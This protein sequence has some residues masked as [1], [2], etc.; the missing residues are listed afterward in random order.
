MHFEAAQ[1]EERAAS[2]CRHDLAG[3]RFTNDRVN[4]PD[5]GIS[6]L[7][8]REGEAEGVL[9]KHHMATPRHAVPT[10]HHATHRTTPR[11]QPNSTYPQ[12]VARGAI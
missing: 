8:A 3:W 2:L 4:G 5:S 1:V 9:H 11:R 6:E 10:P 12:A 7:E